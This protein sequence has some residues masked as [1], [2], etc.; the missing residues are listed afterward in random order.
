MNVEI[1]LKLRVPKGS[2]AKLV[3]HPL[4]QSGF[5]AARVSSAYFD[6]PSLDLKSNAV[7]LRLRK[8]GGKWIQAV[9]GGGGV[10]AGVHT[11][12]EW[13]HAVARG[14]LDFTKIDDPHLVKL[15]GNSEL[16]NSLVPVFSTE[17]SRK[18]VPVEY[19]GSVIECCLD[20]GKILA[21]NRQESISE[22]ELEL[23][24]GAPSALFEFA[25]ELQKTVPLQVEQ[26]S[27][28]ERGYALFLGEKN[29][30]VTKASSVELESKMD[31]GEACRHI[32]MGCLLQIQGNHQGLLDR[33]PDSEYLH[34]MRVGV[35]RMRSAF[36]L[37]PFAESVFTEISPE[38]KWLG[39]ELGPARNWD[40]F[41]EETLPPILAA[42]PDRASLAELGEKGAMLRGR[43][44]KRAHAAISSQRF[45]KLILT[46]G[47]ALSRE[48]WNQGETVGDFAKRMLEKRYRRIIKG[49]RGIATLDA[50]GLHALRISGKKLRYAAEFFS[51][52][53]SSRASRSFLRAM[54]SLQDMLGAINDAATTSHL[55]EELPD[56]EA[57][58]LVR[59]WVASDVRR[60]MAGLDKAWDKYKDI[61]PFWR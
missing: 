39:S 23:K 27:K 28:A 10:L 7:A 50:A 2:M 57:G 60:R 47:L 38:L 5:R 3:R 4:L 15:F 46:L 48:N 36:S 54:A 14:A 31:V 8:V 24:S 33:D 30:K 25:L 43:H 51:T 44:G 20:S 9:K 18:T 29:S 37:F 40:V 34:Q 42:F 17:F 59:G 1:E 35:R 55:L 26:R 41:M 49:G 61:D 6:T 21:E 52:L 16:R 53:Y 58:W 32:V 11:R 22:L 56:S 12:C 19:A 45:Q 13:E